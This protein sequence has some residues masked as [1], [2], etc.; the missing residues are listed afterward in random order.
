[1]GEAPAKIRRGGRYCVA[2]GPNNVGCSNSSYSDGI[3]MHQ[4][5][6]DRERRSKW[7]K[8][9]QQ[10]RRDFVNPGRYAALCSAHFT[11]NCF[12]RSCT[13]LVGMKFHRKLERNAIPTRAVQQ[14]SSDVLSDRAKRQVSETQSM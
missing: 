2:G 9:V 6:R 11:E 12:V 7:I 1:M 10:H 8:F 5:P 14:E 3:S 13:D 4:F